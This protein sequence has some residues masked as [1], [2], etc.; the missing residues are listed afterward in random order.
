MPRRRNRAQQFVVSTYCDLTRLTDR[1]PV[2][3]PAAVSSVALSD[4]HA[5]SLCVHPCCNVHGCEFLE[6]ELGRV[7]DVH[8]GDL[9]LVLAGATLERVLLEVP[10]ARLAQTASFRFGDELV[11]YATGVIRPQI[12]QM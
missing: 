8:L 6:K 10:A 5:R 9:G 11:T 12:S 7:W 4:C 3:L 2:C 1:K